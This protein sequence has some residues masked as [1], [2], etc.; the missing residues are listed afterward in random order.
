MSAG[1]L[2]PICVYSTCPPSG[3]TPPEQYHE[4][5][6]EVARWSDACGCRGILVY[7]DNGLVD[8]WLMAQRIIQE[9]DELTPLV[10]VQP[11]YRHP[12]SVAKLV[13]TLA[14][15]H[16]RGVDLNMLAGGFRNDL[17]ALGDATSHDDRYE[18][19]VEY[20]RI[21]QGLLRG[22]APVTQDGRH[23]HVDRLKLRP[24]LPPELYP[25]FLISGS[26]AAGQRA[27]KEIDAVAVRYPMPAEEYEAAPA[28]ELPAGMRVGIVAR[29]SSEQAWNVARERFPEDRRGQVAH[30]LAMKVSDSTWHQQLSEAANTTDAASPYWL[31]PFKNYKTFCP[32]LVGDYDTVAAEIGR[33][34]EAGF[35]TLITDV[36]VDEEDLIHTSVVLERAGCRI[37]R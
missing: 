16:G 7:T 34:A 26:S 32:Y 27:A 23:Y 10:A 2:R 13:T 14:H 3:D 25:T 17:L 12:Y 31:V 5:V 36:P 20:T 1:E 30:R 21:I 19:T 9:T 15:I 37:A 11:A 18:R 22:D 4:R 28:P 35:R 6:K 33:Y 24:A 29:A 8:P